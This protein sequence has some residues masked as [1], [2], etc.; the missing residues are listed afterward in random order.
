MMIN[1]IKA[2]KLLGEVRDSQIDLVHFRV[3]ISL[4]HTKIQLMYASIIY[5]TSLALCYSSMFWGPQ[6]A[7]FREKERYIFTARS[8]SGTYFV[9]LVVKNVSFVR[10]EDDPLSLE[11]YWSKTVLIKWCEQ[12]KYVLVFV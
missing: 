11:I 2:A 1:S 9:D 5:A 10:L 3:L 12:N 6:R 4:L 8:T 7:I